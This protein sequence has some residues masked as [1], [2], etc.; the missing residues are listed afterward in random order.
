M[1]NPDEIHNVPEHIAKNYSKFSL[2]I[3][4]MHFNGLM[5]L[6]SVS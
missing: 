6:M 3:D 2:Y 4:E 1:P 5:F